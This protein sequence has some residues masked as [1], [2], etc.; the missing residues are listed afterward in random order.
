MLSGK[1]IDVKTLSANEI[2]LNGTDITNSLNN[3]QF[4][5][6]TDGSVTIAGNIKMLAGSSIQWDIVNKPT[7]IQIGA[8]DASWLP[9]YSEIQGTKPPSTADETF[10]A[11]TQDGRLQGI[12]SDGSGKIMINAQYINTKGLTAEKLYNPVN[13]NHYA[14]IGGSSSGMDLT[15]YNGGTKVLEAI[16]NISGVKLAT[17]GTDFLGAAYNI[18]F[19]D[20]MLVSPKGTWDFS[21]ADVQGVK[22]VAVFG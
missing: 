2:I 1:N 10:N 3:N 16:D 4:K 15:L 19:K 21:S 17:H 6:G 13:K 11:L 14:T 8:K 7:P 22:T 20:N 9:D 5:V 12:F 18:H